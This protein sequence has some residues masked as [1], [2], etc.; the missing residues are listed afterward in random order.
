[1]L[2]VE[3]LLALRE[4]RAIVNV[5]CVCISL[6]VASMDAGVRGVRAW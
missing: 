1:M 3:R 4:L 6:C 2:H 5:W